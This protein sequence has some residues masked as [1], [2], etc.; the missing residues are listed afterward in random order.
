MFQRRK[1]TELNYND[2]GN[3]DEE[4]IVREEEQPQIVVLKTGDLD[5]KQVQEEKK[6]LQAGMNLALHIVFRARNK[7]FS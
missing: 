5:S 4:T 6:R 2:D 7:F 3:D 1:L